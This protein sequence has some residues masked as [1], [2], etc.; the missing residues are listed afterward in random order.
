MPRDSR[1]TP[2]VYETPCAAVPKNALNVL[3]SG[4]SSLPFSATTE[5]YAPPEFKGVVPGKVPLPIGMKHWLVWACLRKISNS[6]R[7]DSVI[8]LSSIMSG[9]SAPSF[10]S[11]RF[12]DLVQAMYSPPRLSNPCAYV[13]LTWPSRWNFDA[14]PWFTTVTSI[15]FGA[16]EGRE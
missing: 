6:P 9:T 3:I 5:R 8:H 15:P 13:S 2:W 11:N 7:D 16:E 10:T 1:H 14:V 4:R 12:S